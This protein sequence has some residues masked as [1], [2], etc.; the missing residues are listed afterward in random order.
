MTW[1]ETHT[2]R[3]TRQAQDFP[4]PLGPTIIR[5]WCSWVI[6]YSWR[7][8]RNARRPVSVTRGGLELQHLEGRRKTRVTG[9]RRR[10]QRP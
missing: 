5:P 9:R 2:L 8:W 4:L 6:W 10:P 3:R 1:W 7:T